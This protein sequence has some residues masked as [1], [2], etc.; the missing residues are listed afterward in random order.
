MRTKLG[1]IPAQQSHRFA[2]LGHVITQAVNMHEAQSHHHQRAKSP[3]QDGFSS[4]LPAATAAAVAAATAA[5]SP[6]TSGPKHF[7]E[8]YPQQQQQQHQT[9]MHHQQPSAM[10]VVSHSSAF[11]PP[12]RPHSHPQIFLPQPTAEP[13][14]PQQL[15]LSLSDL[16]SSA[17]PSPPQRRA[18]TPSS[19]YSSSAYSSSSYEQYLSP[20]A[21]DI[22]AI[23]SH[24]R[25]IS[26]DLRP[27]ILLPQRPSP[28]HASSN[29]QYPPVQIVL[30]AICAPQ[31]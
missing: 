30:P 3:S 16:A 15:D 13:Q 21:P 24:K 5:P 25:S 19:A 14:L 1:T 31:D 8:H 23:E 20:Y 6:F 10:S 7:Q 18:S 28:L 17:F 26:P 4:P 9:A 22:A 2:G 29:K 11:Q 27:E 12:L